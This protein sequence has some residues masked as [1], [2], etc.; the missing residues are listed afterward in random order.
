MELPKDPRIVSTNNRVVETTEITINLSDIHDEDFITVTVHPWQLVF[1]A[2]DNSGLG[3]HEN[4]S[5]ENAVRLLRYALKQR[6]IEE[7]ERLIEKGDHR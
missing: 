4:E 6:M 7:G 2:I 3:S 5:I 1:N